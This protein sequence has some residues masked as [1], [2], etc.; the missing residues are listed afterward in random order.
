MVLASDA[1]LA[2]W[3][4]TVGVG[5]SMASIFP[6]MLALAGRRISITGRIT[7]WLLVGA[8]AG[9]MTLPWLIG[10]LFESVGP[11]ATMPAILIDLAIA[12]SVFGVLT[13]HGEGGRTTRTRGDWR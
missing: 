4:G 8:G 7:G 13:L 9:G 2:V 12:A 1:S 3:A 5:L 10:Q 11:R 6:L